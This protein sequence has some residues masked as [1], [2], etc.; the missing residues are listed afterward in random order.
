MILDEATSNVDVETDTLMQRVISEGFAGWTVVCIAHRLNTIMDADRVAVLEGGKL[1]EFG[2]P[3]E[4][5]GR[6]SAF[7]R[8]H[9]A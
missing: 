6:D 3:G 7:R 8:L 2:A 5:M 9:G 1:V 4:L